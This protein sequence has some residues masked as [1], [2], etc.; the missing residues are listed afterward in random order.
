M[1]NID[2]SE[3]KRNDTLKKEDIRNGLRE[4]NSNPLMKQSD[5]SDNEEKRKRRREIVFLGIL[6]VGPILIEDQDFKD[7]VSCFL[8]ITLQ[9]HRWYHSTPDGL[10]N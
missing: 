4:V 7:Q 5:I 10:G 3:E 6:F 2:I 1:I 9:S 8:S